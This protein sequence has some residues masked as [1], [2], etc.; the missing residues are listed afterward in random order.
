VH[1]YTKQGKGLSTEE[2]IWIGRD[3]QR[4]GPYTEASIREWL[5]AGKLAPDALAWRKGEANWVPVSVLL[6]ATFA[7]PPPPP[8]PPPMASRPYSF[9]D[10][11]ATSGR[12]DTRASFP[13]PPAL[14]WFALFLL[15]LVTFGIFGWV[16]TFVQSTWVKRID[17]DSKA[18]LLF[19]LGA[20]GYVLGVGFSRVYHVGMNPGVVLLGLLLMLGSAVVWIVAYFSMAGSLRRDAAQRGLP[21]EIGGI[22]LFFF[23]GT[24]RRSCRGSRAGKTPAAPRRPHRRRCSGY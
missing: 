15:S 13:R 1:R 7:E 5:A 3:G 6:G 23:R 9:F 17:R 4:Y 11:P 18:T 24:S 21:L 12:A 16:W 22:T 8:E 10:V 2:L 14:H 20:A 19:A